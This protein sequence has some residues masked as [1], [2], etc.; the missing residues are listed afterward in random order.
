MTNQVHITSQQCSI[1]DESNK[2]LI[3]LP[4]TFVP[5]CVVNATTTRTINNFVRLAILQ[6]L[7]K[8]TSVLTCKRKGVNLQT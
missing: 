6:K 5:S 3:Y 2:K 7:T 4:E 1:S 8:V